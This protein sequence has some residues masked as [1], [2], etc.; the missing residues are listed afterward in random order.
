MMSKHKS[1][2][3]FTRVIKLPPA[4]GDWT[5]IQ[6]RDSDFDEINITSVSGI[7][8]DSLPRERLKYVHYLH[9]RFAEDLVEKLSNDLSFKVELH[10]IAASQMVYE[11]YLKNQ[12]QLVRFQY[13]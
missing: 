6:Y 5:T 12:Y 11:D 1:S 10:S 7:N 3:E 13:H 4:I 9:Y 2:F 8:F